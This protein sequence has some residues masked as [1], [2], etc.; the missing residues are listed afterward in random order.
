[1]KP[2]FPTFIDW[3]ITQRCNLNCP[4]C[5]ATSTRDASPDLPFSVIEGFVDELV[6][7]NLF[8]VSI[9]GGE[10]FL[11]RDFVDILEL[12]LSGGISAYTSTNG[13]LI[14]EQLAGRLT[15]IGLREIQVSIDGPTDVVH[16]SIRGAQSFKK[17][18]AAVSALKGVGLR[19]IVSFTLLKSNMNTV[20]G[21]VKLVG[22]LDADALK[23]NSVYPAGRARGVFDTINPTESDIDSIKG[24]LKNINVPGLQII[25]PTNFSDFIS[26]PVVCKAGIF[27]LYVS[28]NGDVYPCELLKHPKFLCGNIV[29]NTMAGVWETS[30]VLGGLRLVWD[31]P[32]GKCSTC[33]DFSACKGGCRARAF[34]DSNDLMPDPRCSH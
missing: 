33:S 5:S 8:Q 21:M 26:G 27:N 1:M 20:P 25:P 7:N 14:T 2:S 3:D 6:G 9:S 29:D 13:T 15:D 23:I 11:R 19:V 16:D 30:P 4:Y 18:T 17:A 12:I 24:Y 22:E 31:T 32:T 34:Y 10:P 28:S